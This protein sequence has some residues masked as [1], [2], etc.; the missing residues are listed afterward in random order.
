MVSGHRGLPSARLFTDL[1]KLTE[2]DIFILKVLDQTLTYEVDQILTVDP[3]DLSALAIDPQ[4]D[5]CTLVTC[6]PYGINTHR[7]LV[8]GH[9]VENRTQTQD[10]TEARDISQVNPVLILSLAAGVIII[11][12]IILL[13]R[14]RRKN[15]R[16]IE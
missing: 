5:Y 6:T 7:L 4:Q 10:I 8:R 15:R 3:Y 1:D 12:I 14:A 16:N 9:R 13:V 2:G 11:L